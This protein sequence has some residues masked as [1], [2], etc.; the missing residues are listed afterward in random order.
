MNPTN[1][2]FR[3]HDLR[4]NFIFRRFTLKFLVAILATF[5]FAAQA[6]PVTAPLSDDKAREIIS[7]HQ[8]AV[9]AALA[10]A[11]INPNVNPYNGTVSRFGGPGD[12]SDEYMMPMVLC[13]GACKVQGCLKIIEIFKTGNP[14]QAIVR[15]G[16]CDQI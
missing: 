10:D 15:A 2:I 12:Y 1:L 3:K 7:A 4:F 8:S 6:L 14:Q 13:A 5:S 9:D 16:E 11:G